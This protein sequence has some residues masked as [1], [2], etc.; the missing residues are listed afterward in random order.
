MSRRMRSIGIQLLLRLA[1]LAVRLAR[2]QQR[3]AWLAEL[4][5]IT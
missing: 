1:V 3:R 4:E 5:S 2:V